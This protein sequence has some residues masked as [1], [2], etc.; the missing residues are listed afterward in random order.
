MSSF[1]NQLWNKNI[2]TLT[3][4]LTINNNNMYIYIILEY[5]TKIHYNFHDNQVV[6]NIR[7]MQHWLVMA[8]H[9]MQITKPGTERALK[10]ALNFSVFKSWKWEE[11]SVCHDIWR[12]FIRGCSHV[13]GIIKYKKKIKVKKIIHV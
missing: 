6:S 12:D 7:S 10:V 1:L 3:K 4:L 2:Y 8:T 13:L 5:P 11:I 9:R